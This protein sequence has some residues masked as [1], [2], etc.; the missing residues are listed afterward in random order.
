MPG[1]AA[2]GVRERLLHETHIDRGGRHSLMPG[3]AAGGVRERLLR[4]THTAAEGGIL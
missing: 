4:E 2:S 1:F 3:F